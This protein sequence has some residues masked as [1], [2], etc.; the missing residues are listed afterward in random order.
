MKNEFK[1]QDPGEG[2]HEVEILEIMVSE[3]DEI[4]EG[5]EVMAVESDK[6]AIE[7]PSPFAGKVAEIRVGQGDTA[8][9]GDVLMVVEDDAEAEDDDAPD[10]AET[11]SEADGRSDSEEDAPEDQDEEAATGVDEDVSLD[12]KADEEARDAGKDR[13]EDEE[14][15]DKGGSDET[16]EAARDSGKD[17]DSDKP[18]DAAPVRAAPAAR[19]LA[20]EKGVE[21]ADL[22]PSG[23][24]GQVTVE[25]VRKATRS[26]GTQAE[27][28]TDS[29]EFGPVQRQRISAIR[30]ATARAM[31]RS[32]SEIPHVSHEDAADITELELWRRRQD[33]ADRLSLT[34]II[35][36]TVVAVLKRHPR[37][38]AV[39]DG[40]AD[41]IIL[42]KYW[43]IAI[44]TA[45]DRGLVTPVLKDADRKS[46]RDL[47][48]EIVTLAKKAKDQK[49]SK[50]DLAGGT[51][52]ITNVGAFGGRG[53]APL[54][55]PPQTA[56]LG[57][58]RARIEA[59]VTSDLDAD[60]PP[61]VE[62]RMILPLALSFDHR[63]IDGANA[64]RFVNEIVGLLRDPVSL[65][66]ET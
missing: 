13:S 4:S 57:V 19:K 45:T 5:Q 51:F 66:L 50:S 56:I 7:L 36:K 29:D 42:R 11:A 37:F 23:K 10:E 31:T 41:E 25:D 55:N 8:S 53:L 60:G 49:L 24:D 1:L 26:A 38:N 30:A 63:A 46:A 64:A 34:P 58:G 28:A 2:I 9:V 44:A 21:L 65:A 52:T 15:T 39:Y 20:R 35:A 61:I 40:E 6:A 22:E 48:Q 12:D 14:D 59:V 54:I 43:N 18:S 3:G 16:D 17:R 47:G 62:P 32:W 27:D 33:E